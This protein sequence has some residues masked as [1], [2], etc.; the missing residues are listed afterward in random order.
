[1]SLFLM[2]LNTF[3]LK[4]YAE[5]LNVFVD[6]CLV[7]VKYLWEV[8]NLWSMT[9]CTST[10]QY[11]RIRNFCYSIEVSFYDILLIERLSCKKN[12]IETIFI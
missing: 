4:P 10:K 12:G 6:T 1:M 2:I 9:Y 7:D 3:D 8:I 5:M 11:F